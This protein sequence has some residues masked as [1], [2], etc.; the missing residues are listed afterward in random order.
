MFFYLFISV[1]S[2]RPGRGEGYKRTEVCQTC[3]KTRNVCQSCILDLEF[4]LP[5]QLR[6][7]VLSREDDQVHFVAPE[8]DINREYHLQQRIALVNSGVDL[9]SDIN[10][11][12]ISIA[13]S[14]IANRTKPR[15]NIPVAASALGKRGLNEASYESFS[16]D[17]AD[18]SSGLSVVGFEPLKFDVVPVRSAYTI[19][20]PPPPPPVE[21][22]IAE[23]ASSTP[24]NVAG[25]KEAAGT[26][27]G[28]GTAAEKKATK[29][30]VLHPPKPPAGP[31]PPSAFVEIS[32]S[33]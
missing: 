7:A 24:A 6:D 27:T 14:N 31:P 17:D 18:G 19:P 8:S 28:T 3:A 22:T 25:A 33:S 10:E 20:P 2:W 21:E 29:K 32:S 1:Y 9:Q 5:S 13:R 4:G 26:G 15:V 12:V 11:R 16:S 23:A 30:K